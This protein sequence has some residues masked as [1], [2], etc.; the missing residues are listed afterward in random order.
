M[1]VPAQAPRCTSE[2]VQPLASSHADP[3]ALNAVRARRRP[4]PG[5]LADERAET[6][7]RDVIDHARAVRGSA[8]GRVAAEPP[9]ESDLCR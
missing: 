7:D 4:V 9:T 3:F 5:R 1:G 8:P 2:T 6:R